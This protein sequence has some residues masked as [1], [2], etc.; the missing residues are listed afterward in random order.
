MGRVEECPPL[1]GSVTMGILMVAGCSSGS[2]LGEPNR[3]WG[4]IVFT[5]LSTF[6]S[7]WASQKGGR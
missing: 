5:Y 3:H 1:L 6:V 7:G 4:A 2:L